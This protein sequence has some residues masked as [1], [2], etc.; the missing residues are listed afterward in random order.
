MGETDGAK[1]AYERALSF[2]PNSVQ[3]M[4][5]IS[6]ILRANDQ[7]QPAVEYLHQII[8]IDPL[9]GETWSSLGEYHNFHATFSPKTVAN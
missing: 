2:N 5:A 9:N 1:M 6:C 8:R 4:I 3:A 7:F